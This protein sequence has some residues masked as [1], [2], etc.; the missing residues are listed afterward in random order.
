MG[1]LDAMLAMIN[2]AVS[3]FLLTLAVGMAVLFGLYQYQQHPD[4]IARLPVIKELAHTFQQLSA[5]L[6]TSSLSSF[7]SLGVSQSS[8]YSSQLYNSGG[9]LIIPSSWHADSIINKLQFSKSKL[10]QA[11]KYVAYIE[12]YKAIALR[13]MH[14][15]KVPASIKLAQGLLESGAGASEL[16]TQTNNHF[17]IK[18]RPNSSARAKI[19]SRQY[20]QLRNEEF[21]SSGPAIGAMR[22][23]DDH[24]YDRFEV[25]KNAGDSY[26]RHTQLLTR[27]CKAGRKGC[28]S[29]IWD[30]FKVGKDYDITPAAE[31]HYRASGIPAATFFKG[32]TQLPYYAA[33][34]AGLKMAGY[35]TSPTYHKKLT[36]IIETYELWRFD[37]DLI[38]AMEQ[39]MK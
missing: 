5:P 37:V 35:A 22:F 1:A 30:E 26:H 36:Y 23:T 9:Q 12:Q 27:P 31:L 7:Y 29:W 10:R 14:L 13:D 20:E 24:T 3:K 11:K 38:K 2:G 39:I 19:K 17:G 21:L 16:S 18:A 6:T 15:H 32:R 34:A 4:E 8:I 25:Y 28:Y 33:C